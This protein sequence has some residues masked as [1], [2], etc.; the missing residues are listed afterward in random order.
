MR[1]CSISLFGAYS[2]RENM[3]NSICL[4][5]DSSCFVW[6]FIDRC[7]FSTDRGEDMGHNSRTRYCFGC[8]HI[9]FD[10]G[11]IFVERSGYQDGV[12]R[13]TI[14]GLCHSVDR[15]GLVVFG[16]EACTQAPLTMNQKDCCPLSSR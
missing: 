12:A 5:S 11:R 10:A 3:E 7:F 15:I 9:G 2:V 14:K 13:E 1:R 6:S 16:E 4:D 8:G